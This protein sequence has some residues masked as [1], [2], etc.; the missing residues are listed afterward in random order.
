MKVLISPAMGLTAKHCQPAL[1]GVANAVDA[2]MDTDGTQ[3]QKQWLAGVD[4]RVCDCPARYDSKLC[5]RWLE[6]E[7]GK[8]L[9][10]APS[11]SGQ[12]LRK[13]FLWVPLTLAWGWG[14]DTCLF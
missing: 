9:I 12:I 2:C 4:A 13:I 8:F 10:S 3:Q 11:P 1:A 7:L 6:T 14:G 5:M